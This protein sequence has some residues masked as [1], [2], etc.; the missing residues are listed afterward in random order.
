MVLFAILSFSRMEMSLDRRKFDGTRRTGWMFAFIHVT[1]E[2]IAVHRYRWEMMDDVQWLSALV[3][4]ESLLSRLERDD[5][6][7]SLP[8]RLFLFV[9]VL[10]IF[11]PSAIRICERICYVV[12]CRFELFNLK[13]R[14]VYVREILFFEEKKRER[15]FYYIVLYFFKWIFSFFLSFKEVDFIL[16]NEFFLERLII[17]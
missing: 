17:F 16:I 6:N 11:Y 12:F 9:Y 10:E 1:W 5:G 15:G 13:D 8:C 14:Y 3:S 7:D 4:I 2:E